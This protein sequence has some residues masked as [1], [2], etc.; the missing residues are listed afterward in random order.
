MNP[1]FLPAHLTTA[2]AVQRAPDNAVSNAECS[3][4]QLTA[5][6]N[7]P[8]NTSATNRLLLRLV[9]TMSIGFS[10]LDSNHWNT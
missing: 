2:S 9:C 7:K 3:S 5:M 6:L 10:A 1:Q 4:Y 8:L